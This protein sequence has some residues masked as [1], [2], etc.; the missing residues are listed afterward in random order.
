MR[1]FSGRQHPFVASLSQEE[2]GV[3]LPFAALC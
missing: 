3:T 1:H 2:K